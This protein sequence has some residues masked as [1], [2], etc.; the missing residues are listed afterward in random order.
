VGERK[1][2]K[3]VSLSAYINIF[4]R[5]PVKSNDI[6]QTLRIQVQAKPQNSRWKGII[7]SIREIKK[8][9]TRKIM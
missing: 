7:K 5:S 8:L 4:K 6:T 2:R 1:G 3:F 9:E